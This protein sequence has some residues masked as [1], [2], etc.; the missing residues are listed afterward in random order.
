MY[1]P[2]HVII[3][4]HDMT[5]KINSELCYSR[6]GINW[7]TSFLTLTMAFKLTLYSSFV[8]VPG[9]L[10]RHWKDLYSLHLCCVQCDPW[11]GAWRVFHTTIVAAFRFGS[12]PTQARVQLHWTIVSARSWCA[13]QASCSLPTQ[14]SWRCFLHDLCDRL[15]QLRWNLFVPENRIRPSTK[16]YSVVP[17]KDL[18]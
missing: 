11:R 16:C 17:H 1:I 7:V 15:Q 4:G 10:V 18:G 5:W 3:W 14:C 9:H 8:A 13:R 6:S 2:S 12:D